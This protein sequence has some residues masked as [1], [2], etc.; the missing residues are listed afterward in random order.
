MINGEADLSWW[1][2]ST[3]RDFAAGR[4]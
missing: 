3:N 1:L 2:V 4:S